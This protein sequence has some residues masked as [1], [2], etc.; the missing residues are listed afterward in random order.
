MKI[1]LLLSCATGAALL[2]VLP[3]RPQAA[4]SD[5]HPPS[6]ALLETMSSHGIEVGGVA[7][8]PAFQ[9]VAYAASGPQ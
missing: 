5:P 2:L 4:P 1:A 9:P 7:A 3:H 6:A 8:A